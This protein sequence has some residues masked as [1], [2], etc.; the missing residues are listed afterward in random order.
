MRQSR[1]K[2]FSLAGGMLAREK[3]WRERERSVGVFTLNSYECALQSCF[4]ECVLKYDC[5]TVRRSYYY[6][7]TNLFAFGYIPGGMIFI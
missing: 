2:P 1:L 3:K 5:D 7:A 4:Y 6:R